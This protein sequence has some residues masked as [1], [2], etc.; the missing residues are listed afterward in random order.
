ML[1]FQIDPP[2][3]VKDTPKPRPLGSL[4]EA[5][6]FVAEAMRLGRPPPWRDLYERL[7]A[8][9]SEEEAIEVIGAL[10][11]LLDLEDLLVP[12]KLGFTRA[13]RSPEGV[14]AP[15]TRHGENAMI[16]DV[17]VRLD[18]TA[19]DEVRLAAVNDIAG[20]FDSQVI[21]LFLNILPVVVAAEDGIGA[22][23]AAELLEAGRAAGDKVEAKLRQRL[24]R[25]QR[26]VE[27]RRF[28]ILDDDVQNV[29]TREARAADTFVALRPNGA[30]QEPEY[31]VESV[32]FGS[33]RH[34]FLVPNRRPA[35]ATLDRILVAW[36]GGRES[37]RALGEALPY[38]HHATEA[39]VVVVDD[40]PALE[41]KAVVG[42]DAVNHLK[43]HDVNA[44]LHRV[45]MRDN[46]VGM[47]LIAEARRL[48][49]DLIVMGGY[50]HSRV[51]EWVLGGATH[52]LL[53]RAPIPLLIAH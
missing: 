7:R 42:P 15:V 35:K 48:K 17:M 41:T 16:K 45:R 36:N 8:V 38:L 13:P 28:D 14:G 27:L 30:P 23:R 43:H 31:L 21:G 1:D 6:A 25:L 37:A 2:L 5:G 24:E 44:V 12:P 39:A 33:G 40:E 50:G 51:R 53:H 18:G 11:E 34:V 19:A 9:R 49:A 22:T 4:A 26:P 10:R 52:T 32:L 20:L 47:T 46:D 3:L 29:V